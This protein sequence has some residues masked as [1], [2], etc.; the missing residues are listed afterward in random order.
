VLTGYKFDLGPKE[1]PDLKTM[2]E[3]GKKIGEAKQ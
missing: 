1:I 3:A 2:E